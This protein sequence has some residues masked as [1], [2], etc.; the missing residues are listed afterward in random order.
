MNVPGPG[1]LEQ[2]IELHKS[3]IKDI[4]NFSFD[5]ETNYC[6]N[7]SIDSLNKQLQHVVE[8]TEAAEKALQN[9]RNFLK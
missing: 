8:M 3:L 2:E 7:L 5:G 4:D 1:H 9:K 6:D